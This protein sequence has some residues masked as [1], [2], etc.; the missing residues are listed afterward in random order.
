MRLGNQSRVWLQLER[1]KP[2]APRGA[3]VLSTFW[4]D[5]LDGSLERGEGYGGQE[6]PARPQS[7]C[8]PDSG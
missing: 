6:G 1:G 3:A 7:C 2:G 4:K 8:G 5:Q